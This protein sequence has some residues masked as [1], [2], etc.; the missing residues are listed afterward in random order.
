MLIIDEF[1]NLLFDDKAWPLINQ[2]KGDD[3]K[4]A[5]TRLAQLSNF[6]EP[7]ISETLQKYID[8]LKP[9]Q[10]Y[11]P[12]LE[13]KVKLTKQELRFLIIEI[14]KDHDHREYAEYALL[15]SFIKKDGQI[16]KKDKDIALR[17]K[18]REGY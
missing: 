8:T 17:I 10:I 5:Y 18:K 7:T 6:K 1:P 16:K 14:P 12:I 2:L 9:R 3:K 11:K 13:I 4:S 15:H